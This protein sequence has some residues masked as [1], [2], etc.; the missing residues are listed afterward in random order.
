M[1]GNAPDV[2]IVLM[3]ARD[4]LFAQFGI[5]AILTA[6]HL[7]AEHYFLYWRVQWFDISVHLLGGLWAG[8][9][10]AWIL[11]LF[12]R[13]SRLFL[14]ICVAVLFGAVWELFEA[15]VGMIVFPSDTLDTMKDLSMDAVGGIAAYVLALKITKR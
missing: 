12:N 10:A 7:A 5:A 11:A 9:F 1:K 8:L 13:S 3:R 4:L 6:F 15:K 14:F 2:T